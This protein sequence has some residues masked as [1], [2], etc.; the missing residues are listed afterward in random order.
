MKHLLITIIILMSAS[1]CLANDKTIVA[2][3]DPW[4][5][6]VD[7]TSATEGLSLEV[8][9]AAFGTQGYTVKM[10]YVPW[11]RAEKGVKEGK[12]DILP[13]T[14][15]TEKR[16]AYLMYSDQYAENEVKFIT[17]KDDT[18]EFTG[19]ESL[20]G[21]KVG[22]VRSYGY[23]DTFSNATNFTREDAVDFQTNIKKL[24][25]AKKRIDMTLEDE[26]VARVAIAKEDPGLLDKIRFTENALSS[27]PL[28]VTCGLANPRHEEIIGAF[29]KGL[30]EIKAS[31]EYAEILAKYGIK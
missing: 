17:A 4:P 30:A 18:F 3:A 1:W 15:F 31:G 20:D 25:S 5:P 28:H 27:N 24:T 14:W 6:F 23:G 9:R 7:P 26:I 10:E 22:T 8:V 13:N 21:K 11:V 29:N 2:A 19:M 12:Y 16:K